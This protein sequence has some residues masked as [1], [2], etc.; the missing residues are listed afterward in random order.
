MSPS[1]A[2]PAL[3]S[4]L[5]GLRRR[6]RELS[7]T[8]FYDARG[9]R[10][11]EAI[12]ELPEYY[13]T[14]TERG[15]LKRL[16]GPWMEAVRPATLVELGAGSAHKTRLLLDAAE[17]AGSGRCFV[18]LDVSAEHL[19]AAAA[20]V[21]REYPGLDVRPVV[22]DMTGPLNLPADLPR[23]LLVALLGSTLGNFDDEAA[24]RLLA[25]VRRLLEPG[26]A[27]LLGV[28]LA[29]GPAKSVAR[30]EAAYNDARGVT[31]EFN[32][33][34]L[35]VL[36]RELG[37]D[38]DLGGFAHR[39]VYDPVHRRIEMYLVARGRQSVAFGDGTRITL[40]GGE[41]IRTEI[42]C[43]Y[44]RARIEG[45]LERAGLRLTAWSADDEGLFALALGEPT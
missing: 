23:P 25:R 4:V 31:A 27:L 7:P 22:G 44:D 3:E 2:P 26:D 35:R 1:T 12:T 32:L 20:E 8:W 45:V 29:P 16:A 10:L 14:R 38:F 5:A 24:V 28:D 17:A 41:S 37:A 19:Q 33:N 21:D 36:N 40:E 18:P 34:V 11:F 15:L 9:S 39:A 13:L 30:L 42:S 6:P 43:K